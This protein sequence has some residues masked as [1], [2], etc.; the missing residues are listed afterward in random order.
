MANKKNQYQKNAKKKE[1]LGGMPTAQETKGNVK[2]SAMATGKDILI[3]ALGGGLAGAIVGRGSLF[4]GV[5]ITGAGHYMGQSA[6]TAFG[7]GMMSSGGYQ[8]LKGGDLKGLDGLQGV[9]ERVKAFSENVK[10]RLFLDKVIKSKKKADDAD[11]NGVGDVQ[12]Y[13]YPEL[14]GSEEE[15]MREIERQIAEASQS[16]AGVG[17]IETPKLG[18]ED[19]LERNL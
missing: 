7:I 11:V 10:N 18:I 8:A 13:A 17:E 6:M 16:T 12:Y 9:K 2:A 15:T 1:L 14:Q 19:I 3:G 4:I 5:A